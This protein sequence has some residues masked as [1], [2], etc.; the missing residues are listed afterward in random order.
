MHYGKVASK[1]GGNL[2]VAMRISSLINIMFEQNE[3]FT[4]EQLEEQI[5]GL[6]IEIQRQIDEDKK[7]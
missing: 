5:E 3:S 6:L 7:D 1:G 2:I 4:R